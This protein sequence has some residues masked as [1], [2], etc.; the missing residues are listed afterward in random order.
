MTRQW[1]RSRAIRLHADGCA[2]L[3]R[4]CLRTRSVRLAVATAR[5]AGGLCRSHATVEQCVAMG[6]AAADR[7]AHP[8]C[9]YRAL[10]VYALLVRRHPAVQ[11]HLG[12]ASGAAFAT[13]AWVT[14]GG[15]ALDTDAQRYAILWSAA[16]EA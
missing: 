15:N 6:T 12:A 1:L 10:T 5:A 9:L 11:F 8:T 4:I 13:H 3:I 16:S 14:V 2:L 7:L